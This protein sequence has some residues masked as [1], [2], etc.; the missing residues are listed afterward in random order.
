MFCSLYTVRMRR[1]LSLYR[2][3]W[4]LFLGHIDRIPPV[5][6][7]WG[8]GMAVF[9]ACGGGGRG[10]GVLAAFFFGRLTG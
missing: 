9:I 1:R 4:L 8:R 10:A 6:P 7:C 2:Y 3:V 5:R